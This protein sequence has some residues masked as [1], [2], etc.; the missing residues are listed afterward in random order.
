MNI[1]YT[2]K[3]I[4]TNLIL[5]IGLALSSVA[6]DSNCEYLKKSCETWPCESAVDE[7]GEPLYP[8][9]SECTDEQRWGGDNP[10][11]PVI[12]AKC[13]EGQTPSV[14]KP[15]TSTPEC[16]AQY[17]F[18]PEKGNCHTEPIGPCGGKTGYDC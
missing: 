1:K 11:F 12:G 6:A 16:A 13:E 7:N 9:Q 10:V 15:S 3:N 17:P 4:L 2:S 14:I 18:D 5:C 8:N